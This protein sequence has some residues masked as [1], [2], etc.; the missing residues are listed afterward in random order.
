VNLLINISVAVNIVMIALFSVVFILSFKNDINPKL[1]AKVGTLTG[2]AIFLY[3]ICLTALSIVGFAVKNFLMASLIFF[4]IMLFIIGR[5]V[6]YKT[7]KLF[8][9]IQLFSFAL[10]LYVLFLIK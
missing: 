9:V 1:R 2:V 4:V 6:C 10:S 8:S 7:L 3:L 5:F